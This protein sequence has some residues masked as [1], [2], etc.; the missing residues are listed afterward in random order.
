MCWVRVCVC[1]SGVLGEGV[2]VLGEGVCAGL[3]LYSAV[4]FPPFISHKLRYS[5]LDEVSY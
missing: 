1:W 5:R 3:S 4:R 2:C